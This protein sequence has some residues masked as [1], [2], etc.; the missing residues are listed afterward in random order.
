MEA[1]I[2]LDNSAAFGFA[3]N[4]EAAEAEALRLKNLV[5]DIIDDLEAVRDAIDDE[6]QSAL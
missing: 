1:Q 4:A 5:S 6:A 3:E 2:D